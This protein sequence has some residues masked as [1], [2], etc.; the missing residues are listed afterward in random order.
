MEALDFD[1]MLQKTES[2]TSKDFF[3][4]AQAAEQEDN[5][6]VAA[7]L[8]LQGGYE[9]RA[10]LMYEAAGEI[11]KAYKLLIADSNPSMRFAADQFAAKHGIEGR[12]Y[13]NIPSSSEVPF[14]TAMALALKSH[15][16]E[17]STAEDLGFEGFQ[18]KIVGDVGTRDGRF[19]NLFYDLGA[20]EVYG[21]DPNL[22]DLQKAI[23]QGILDAEHAV[24]CTLAEMPSEIRDR[25]DIYAVFNF[26]IAYNE[27]AEFFRDMRAALPEGGQ[28]VA[29][30]AETFVL[31][32]AQEHAKPYFSMRSWP[33][34]RGVEGDFPHKHLSIFTAK[35]D[36]V[37]TTAENITS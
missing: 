22:R 31:Q 4:H 17:G 20:A 23:D 14:D 1:S 13:S 9:Y 34:W 15:L 7:D 36:T 5:Y 2:F 32:Y 3:E 19:V 37:I 6:L 29:T 25:I 18:D 30:F 33:L 24:G 12:V 8:Y 21:I 26:N 27:Q 35:P 28:V 10:S 16:R 11:E